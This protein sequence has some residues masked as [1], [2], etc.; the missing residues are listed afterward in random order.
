MDSIG[1]IEGPSPL[2]EKPIPLKGDDRVSPEQI[3]DELVQ[4]VENPDATFSKMSSQMIEFLTTHCP[5]EM[6]ELNQLV[7]EEHALIELLKDVGWKT[8]K[9]EKGSSM[10]APGAS[11]RSIEQVRGEIIDKVTNLCMGALKRVG[12]DPPGG[13][14]AY[15]TPG[16]NSDVDIVYV[17]S[18]GT[19]EKMQS[20]EK[21][22][23]DA[24]FFGKFNKLSG[25]LLDTESYLNHPGASCNTESYLQTDLGKS[26]YSNLELNGAVFQLFRQHDPQSKEWK[27]LEEKFMHSVSIELL[28]TLSQTLVQAKCLARS[29]QKESHLVAENL[30]CPEDV[31]KMTYKARVVLKLGEAMDQAHAK[32]KELNEMVARDPGLSSRK[33]YIQIKEE[34]SIR[35][36][37]L[38]LL[39][40][41]FFDEGYNAQGTF[42]KI[43][44]VKGGQKHQR[45]I[46]TYQKEVRSIYE[47]TPEES[48]LQ[49]LAL[50]GIYLGEEQRTMSSELQEVIS[51]IENLAMYRNH[52]Q[53]EVQGNSTLVGLQKAL[54]GQSKYSERA[55]GSALT[56]LYK[57][58]KDS[59][60]KGNLPLDPLLMTE[61]TRAYQMA[62]DMEQVKRQRVLNAVTT[63][64]LLIDALVKANPSTPRSEIE[65]IVDIT[66]R[67][68]EE[69]I[70]RFQM[71]EPILPEDLYIQMVSIL[72]T[73]AGPTRNLD[74]Q[75][76][77]ILAHSGVDAIL[78]ARCGLNSNPEVRGCHEKS[79][80]I[81]LKQY[82]LDTVDAISKFN[83]QVEEFTMGVYNLSVTAGI[84][85]SPAEETPSDLLLYSLWQDVISSPVAVL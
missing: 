31:A 9:E 70:K 75:G 4:I 15:G 81:T 35:I 82:G 40:T 55:L 33:D 41:Q 11:G 5:N 80:E 7:S 63:R 20:L 3:R 76:L 52:F 14:L 22:M 53:H 18:K 62:A 49:E 34:L 61:I 78:R 77:P 73:L 59:K 36:A 1:G 26:L 69:T 2:P 83:A 74:T 79:R 10:A 19:P 38:A 32:L 37:S 84:I 25:E 85:P 54:F 44:D 67:K 39:R 42:K 21:I 43:C 45:S 65:N 12:I 29:I 64:F 24:I 57:Y 66:M 8:L 47:E 16:W 58:Q 60:I 13:Y 28:T 27:S 71:E 23:F 72:G 56:I 51:S 30:S 46:E 48:Q 68:N 6:K 17:A 50:T